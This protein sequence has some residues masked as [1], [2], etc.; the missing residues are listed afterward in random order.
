MSAPFEITV[1]SKDG[2]PLTKRIS[3]AP[4]GSVKSDGSACVMST[5]TARRMR[6]DTLQELAVVIASLQSNEALALGALRDDLPDTVRVVPKRKLNGKAGVIARTQDFIDFLPGKPALALFDFDAKGMPDEVRTR[7]SDLG[8]YWSAL[9]SALPALKDA[10][11]VVRRSTSAGLL[12]SD[13]NKTLPGSDGLHVYVLVK[14]GTDIDR[15]LRTLHERCWLAGFGWMMVGAGGQLL[16]RSI[17]D[18]MVGAPE[19][20]IFE[21]P[22]ILVPPITQDRAKR[23]PA[24]IAGDG[25]A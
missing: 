13:T 7:L 11:R 22:P 6:L 25:H 4:D 17:V 24:V 10:P 12:R 19:R 23:C 20:L 18:R 1:F 5:G 16:E 21:G 2:G 9:T 8:G 15:F 3:L 14:D